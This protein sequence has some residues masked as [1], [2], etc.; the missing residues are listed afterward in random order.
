[1]TGII[2]EGY[3]FRQRLTVPCYDTDAA[4]CLKP[5]SFMDMA[6]EI[7]YW[8]AEALGFGYD[9]L[10]EHRTAWVLSRMHIHFTR[11]PKWREQADLETW[12]KGSDGLF[13]LRDFL[14]RSPEGEALVECTSS[15]LVLDIA[16]RRLVRPEALVG[17]LQVDPGKVEDAIAE[18]APK[19]LLP[20]D[21]EPEPAGEHA[22]AY[23]DVDI[24]GHTN[25]ARYM[26][27]AMDALP[28]DTVSSRRVKDVYINFNRETV[29]G[30]TVVLSRICREDACFVEGKVA[31]KS[32]FTAQFVF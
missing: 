5:A 22:V 17:M 3:R 4:F 20:R 25:N 1:M 27:W 29:P 15:W 18:S 21:A 7:A 28:Y 32:V 14:L 12:H 9:A 6:Q 19:I 23:A 13:F 16:T 10:Q 2:R 30:E 8:A 11:I 31:G 24:N 26:V